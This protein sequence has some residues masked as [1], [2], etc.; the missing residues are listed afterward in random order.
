M[1]PTKLTAMKTTD[2]NPVAMGRGG[3]TLIELL[4]VIAIISLLASILIPSLRS[5]K[6]QAEA[7]LCKN[8]LKGTGIAQLLHAQENKGWTT[9]VYEN[10]GR[11]WDRILYDEGF[12]DVPQQGQSSILICP[13]YYTGSDSSYR[14]VWCAVG[15]CYGM[16]YHYY[17]PFRILTPKTVMEQSSDGTAYFTQ[18]PPEEYVLTADSSHSQV[19]DFQW[20]KFIRNK[21]GNPIHLRHGGQANVLFASGHVAGV[22]QYEL[23]SNLGFVPE[24]VVE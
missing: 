6:E 17:R 2:G 10:P 16:R 19:P 14:G 7:V 15:R 9:V 11:T 24:A 20:Y 8:N 21:A 3:F 1:G 23:V 4:V 13:S 5:A 12:I 22:D 18:W